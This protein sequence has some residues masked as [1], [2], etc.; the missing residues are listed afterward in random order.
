M[1]FLKYKINKYFRVR[2]VQNETAEGSREQ[3][4]VFR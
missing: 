3:D 2:E 4:K 1:A